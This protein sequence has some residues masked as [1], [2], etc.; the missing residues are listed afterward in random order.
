MIQANFH[1]HT[2][3]CDGKNTP[4]EMAERAVS[5]G[6]EQL[7]FSGHMDPDIHM[8]FAAYVRE[9]AALRAEFAPR[10]DILCGVELDRRWAGESTDAAEYTIGSTH[11]LPGADGALVA[12]DHTFEKQ[13]TLCRTL[14][15]G[16][17]YRLCAAYFEEEAAV[18]EKTRCDIVGHFDLI[19]RFNHQY[20]R[21]DETDPRYLGPALAAL[22]HLA[23]SGA[24]FELNAGALNRGRRADFYPIRP[25]LTRLCELRAPLF[26]S[27]D[28]HSADLLD[29]G[30]AD[31]ARMAAACGY[32]TYCILR[33]DESG[34]VVR[35]EKEIG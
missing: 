10:L 5:L 14:Y 33:H 19:A 7:G 23:A 29:A 24:A 27:T 16:D 17:W 22:E 8:D 32:R 18:A 26:L 3:L 35:E 13:E 15:G 20:P 1:T 9:I 11:F 2:V 31:A 25:L 28:A 4:R 12:L 21:F 34:R 30:L 6:F